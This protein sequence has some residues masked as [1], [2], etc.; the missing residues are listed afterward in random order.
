VGTLDT[1]VRVP[2]A[3][4]NALGLDP[5][6]NPDSTI[7]LN[8]SL[9]NLDRSGTQD[10]N[11][12]DLMKVTAHEIDE[13]LGGGSGLEGLANGDPI[14]NSRIRPLDLFRYASAGARSFDTQ[15]TTQAF[16]SIDG[17]NT[18]LARFNQLASG[19][20]GDWYSPGGQ[21]PQ[22]QDAFDTKGSKPNL[23]V[24]LRRLDV[25]GYTPV[26]PTALSLTPPAVQNFALGVSTA[27]DLGSVTNGNGPFAVTVNWG[28]GSA[29]TT[30]YVNDPG[31]LGTQNHTYDS[32]GVY[33]PTISVTDFTSQTGSTNFSV[34]SSKPDVAVVAGNV[35]V[36][37]TDGSDSI[38]VAVN[39]SNCRFTDPRCRRSSGRD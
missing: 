11:K 24:E 35:V 7:T 21:T 17:G 34:L 6:L 1:L 39:G 13:T 31:S 12:Y 25:L 38:T 19:D 10:A 4:A 14:G 26:A 16:F 9:M 15:A 29:N 5:G 20:Y 8:T 28:D 27:F 30:S 32:A 18:M 33:T 37:G 36:T 23:N 3:L 22:V 2:S